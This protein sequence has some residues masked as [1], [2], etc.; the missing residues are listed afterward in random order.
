[1][2]VFYNDHTIVAGQ[3]YLGLIDEPLLSAGNRDKP[4]IMSVLIGGILCK[5][6]IE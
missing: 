3:L 1:M 4:L 5:P 2:R 6:F